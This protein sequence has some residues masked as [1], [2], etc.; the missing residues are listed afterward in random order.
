MKNK[1]QNSKLLPGI[2]SDQS[3]RKLAE[4]LELPFYAKYLLIAAYLASNN[5]AKEDKRLYVK[6]HGKQRKRMKTVNAKAKVILVI[7][8]VLKTKCYA[9]ILKSEYF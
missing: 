2:Y 5:S 9:K 8:I 4:C 7:L 1:F 6:Y 3:I